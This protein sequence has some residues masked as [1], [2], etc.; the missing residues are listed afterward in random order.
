M[1]TK[2]EKLKQAG[3]VGAPHAITADDESVVNNLTDDEV[4]AL[5]SVKAK[6]DQKS[7]SAADPQK[8]RVANTIS[9]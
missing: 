6:L 9:F 2:L 7:G 5:I 1:S 8:S 3:I 4:N